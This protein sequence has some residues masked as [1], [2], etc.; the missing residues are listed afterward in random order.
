MPKFGL[1]DVLKA[2]PLVIQV[3]KGIQG[4]KGDRPGAER[5]EAAVEALTGGMGIADILMD[6]SISEEMKARAV[7]LLSS[8]VELGVQA[9]K[10]EN[11][12]RDLTE[13]VGTVKD[14]IEAVWA[15]IKAIR[16][17]SKAA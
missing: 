8:G 2:A 14:Q 16:A 4:L 3:V 13:Q 5:K 1:F 9:M 11:Q 15:E 17:T 7:S 6:D 12:I 10:L